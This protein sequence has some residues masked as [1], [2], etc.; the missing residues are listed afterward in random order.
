[1]ASPAGFAAGWFR[2]CWCSSGIYKGRDGTVN[3][4]SFSFQ[5]RQDRVQSQMFLLL[6]LVLSAVRFPDSE[7]SASGQSN[8]PTPGSSSFVTLSTS[9]A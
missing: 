1:M 4:I 5:F 3:A 2:A 8:H 7:G 6:F 9:L